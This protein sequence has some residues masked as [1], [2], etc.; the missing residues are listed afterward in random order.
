MFVPAQKIE[1][2]EEVVIPGDSMYE[3]ETRL[4]FPIGF[5]LIDQQGYGHRYPYLSNL[6]YQ[7]NVPTKSKIT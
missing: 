2:A 3:K 5:S 1:L 4:T 7:A 6:S